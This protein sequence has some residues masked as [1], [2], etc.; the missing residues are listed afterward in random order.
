MHT[1]ALRLHSMHTLCV[2]IL[3]L[4]PASVAVNNSMSWYLLMGHPRSSKSTG[5]CSAI[6]V[7]SFR[8]LI[9]IGVAYTTR[10]NS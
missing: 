6:G 2:G 1:V 10:M 5:T 4:R 3:G 7:E 9:H 8:V